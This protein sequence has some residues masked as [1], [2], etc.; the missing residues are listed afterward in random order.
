MARSSSNCSTFSLY[1]CSSG[2]EETYSWLWT[3]SGQ[4]F[5]CW[6]RSGIGRVVC[7]CD[8]LHLVCVCWWLE[9]FRWSAF[10]DGSYPK[11]SVGRAWSCCPWTWRRW[12]DLGVWTRCLFIGCCGF[13][14]GSGSVQAVSPGRETGGFVF[15]WV[16]WDVEGSL[17]YWAIP[18]AS[19]LIESNISLL[20][21]NPSKN[22]LQKKPL[23][24][25]PYFLP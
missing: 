23:K 5:W 14:G 12:V 17:G 24:L 18:D 22:Y 7:V 4:L 3:R 16:R 10:L 2:L 19:A 6:M 21:Q 8:S 13:W 1:S 25:Y 11:E 15:W 20:E 9:A